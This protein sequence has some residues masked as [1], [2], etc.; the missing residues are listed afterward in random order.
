MCAV[1]GDKCF[2]A[3]ETLAVRK[4]EREYS[5][6]FTLSIRKHDSCYIAVHHAPHAAGHS[7]QQFSQFKVGNNLIG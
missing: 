6:V 4:I 2:L 5:Q 7:A 3:E 1:D